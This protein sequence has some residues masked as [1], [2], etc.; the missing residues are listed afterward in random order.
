MHAAL[1]IL[2]AEDFKPT[3]VLLHKFLIRQGHTVLLADNGKQALDLYHRHQLDLVLTDI[4]MPILNGLQAIKEIRKKVGDLWVPIII[5]SASDQEKDIIDGLN[6]GADDYLA[7]PIRLEVLN[8]KIHA[9]ERTVAL[10][11]QS[12]KQQIKLKALNDELEQEQLLAKEL[13]GKML[14]QGA[15][16][17]QQI[18]YWLQASGH[19]S[20]DLIA[21]SETSEKKL[22]VLLIDS[23]GH[24]LAA[25]LPI[26]TMAK[27]FHSM[28]KKG[29]SLSSL[30]AEMNES[31]RKLLPEN[32]FIAANLFAFDFKNKTLE[33]WCGGNPESFILNKHGD[34]VHTLVSQHLALGI[35]PPKQFNATTDIWQWQEPIELISYSDGITEAENSLSKPF[36][37]KKVIEILQNTE[38]NKRIA[39]IKEE[40]VSF[41]GNEKGQDDISIVSVRCD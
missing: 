19:F 13:A 6:A 23:T 14:H 22:F 1:T 36:G 24:G 11:K 18:D 4:D 39:K 21:A 31:A 17:H 26:L 9:I 8:A 2:V 29:F 16:G 40:V 32:R 10:Q 33:S 37:E 3:Q 34:V 28:S 38:M 12:L 30:V 41:L 35:L 20:G 27:V 15:L 25:S 5:L 7:K